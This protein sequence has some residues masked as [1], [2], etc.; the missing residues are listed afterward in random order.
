[1]LAGAL[2]GFFVGNVL[3]ARQLKKLNELVPPNSSLA[4]LWADG[5]YT[6]EAIDRWAPPESQRMV[7]R[8]NSTSRASS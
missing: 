7:V 1:M 5:D 4:Y 6:N 8:F 3:S 2:Y